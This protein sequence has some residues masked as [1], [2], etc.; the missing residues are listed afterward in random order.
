[1]CWE[2]CFYN[3]EDCIQTKDLSTMCYNK[4]KKCFDLCL[5]NK[6]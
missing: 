3:I 4:F 6:T 2:K 1:M 5:K